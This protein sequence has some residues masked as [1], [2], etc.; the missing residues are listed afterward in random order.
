MMVVAGTAR[1]KSGTEESVKA[2]IREVVEATRPEDGCLSYTFFFE[3]DDTTLMH[4]FEEWESEAHLDA[5]LALPH[6]QKFLGSLG[7]YLA[8]APDVKRY[9]VSEIKGL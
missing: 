4:V 3:I 9:I 2:L 6:T 8:E 1:L 7:E 5:H